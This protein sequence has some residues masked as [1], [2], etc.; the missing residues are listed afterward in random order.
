MPPLAGKSR[1]ED[2]VFA[3]EHH[4]EGIAWG[5]AVATQNAARKRLDPRA[6]GRLI[7]I[8]HLF[9]RVHLL[10]LECMVIR[11]EARNVS[12]EAVLD[13]DPHRLDACTRQVD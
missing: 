13:L 3:D 7:E 1:E 10:A 5:L 12:Q 9:L 8:L 11:L 4:I 2:R 6:E